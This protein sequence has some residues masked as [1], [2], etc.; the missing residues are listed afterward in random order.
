MSLTVLVSGCDKPLGDPWQETASVLAAPLSLS[1][2]PARPQSRVREDGHLHGRG[3]EPLPFTH[4]HTGHLS[5]Q[6][7]FPSIIPLARTGTL[8]PTAWDGI[9]VPPLGSCVSLGSLL[10][11]SVPQFP[12]P[13]NGIM[14]VPTLWVFVRM[15]RRTFFWD[16]VSTRSAFAKQ[17]K[18]PHPWEVLEF[19][20]FTSNRGGCGQS[21]LWSRPWPRSS[22]A[23]R[24]RR[25]GRASPGPSRSAGGFCLAGLLQLRRLPQPH[26]ILCILERKPSVMVCDCSV[27][28]QHLFK[29]ISGKEA[30]N[31]PRPGRPGWR[32]SE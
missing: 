22:R 16:T 9:P 14:I 3:L 2:H 32:G 20:L 19:S 15:K 1:E 30:D 31:K 5:H 6:L 8:V 10:N 23:C 27:C 26:P 25:Q 28:L 13:S 21:S 4:Q 11:L 17:T 18:K 12:S 24:L 7:L 29:R